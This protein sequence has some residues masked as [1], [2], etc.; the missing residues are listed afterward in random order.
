MTP[1]DYGKPGQELPDNHSCEGCPPQKGVEMN[2]IPYS[3]GKYYTC[4]VCGGPHPTCEHIKYDTSPQKDFCEPPNMGDVVWRLPELWTD[5]SSNQ[6][7]ASR[8]ILLVTGLT[9]DFIAIYATLMGQCQAITGMLTAVIASA[10]GIYF[11]ST[12][13]DFRFWRN[14]RDR[15]EDCK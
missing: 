3:D 12:V 2:K 14:R 5:P 7:S 10:A 8:M 6:L 11:G 9:V 1:D 13:K 4:G 15:D